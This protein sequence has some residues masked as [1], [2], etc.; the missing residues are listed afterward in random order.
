MLPAVSPGPAQ[1]DEHGCGGDGEQTQRQS[2]LKL[3][4]ILVIQTRQADARKIRPDLS[5]SARLID[6]GV[7]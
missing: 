1:A 6:A 2:L 5:L 3:C 4:H 7:L